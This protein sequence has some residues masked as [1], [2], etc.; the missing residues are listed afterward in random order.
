MSRRDDRNVR[1]RV[2]EIDLD[3]PAQFAGRVLSD[4]GAIV[5]KV[6]PVSGDP[7]RNRPPTAKGSPDRSIPFEHFNANKRSIALD[8][9]RD[10]GAKILDDLIR[11]A[12]VLLISP[13]RWSSLGVSARAK[14]NVIASMYGLSASSDRLHA[15]QSALTRYAAGGDANFMPSDRN[16]ELRPTFPGWSVADAMCGVGLVVCVLG[17]TVALGERSEEPVEIDF[18]EQAWYVSL[19]KMFLSRVAHD[20]AVLDRM[21]HT[22]PFGGNMKCLDGY[23]SIL[24]L[25]QHQWGKLCA[26]V[27]RSD[28]LERKD[29]STAAGRNEASEEIDDALCAW[30]AVRTVDSILVAARDADVPAGRV[31]TPQDILKNDVMQRRGFTS[32]RR[33]AFGT[34][35]VAGLPFGSRFEAPGSPE[36]FVAPLPGEHTTEVLLELGLERGK[37]DELLTAGVVKQFHEVGAKS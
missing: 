6:E 33:T 26:M 23:V 11:A 22:Y 5:T 13:S 36:D 15:P 24:I 16:L 10:V 27:G 17:A 8:A 9:D 18:S 14:V 21:T 29:L 37:I 31:A 3:E 34:F 4:L 30:C 25:E 35:P 19:N 2:L 12:D 28:W 7:L 32:Q 1:L 20:G